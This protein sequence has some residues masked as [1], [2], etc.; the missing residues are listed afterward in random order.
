MN[1]DQYMNAHF[2][3]VGAG[4][5]RVA[6]SLQHIE[7]PGERMSALVFLLK[8]LV[9]KHELNLTDLM[10]GVSSM[11]EEAKEAFSPELSGARMYIEKEVT[12]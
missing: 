7:R 1:R 11:E 8:C 9:D 3:R 4:A 10:T 2:K 5:M 12:I 6:D